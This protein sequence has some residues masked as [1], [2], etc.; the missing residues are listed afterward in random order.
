MRSKDRDS[1][2]ETAGTSQAAEAGTVYNKAAHSAQKRKKNSISE[3]TAE[4]AANATLSFSTAAQL[5]S[6]P[7]KHHNHLSV[8][9][10]PRFFNDKISAIRN[11]DPGTCTVSRPR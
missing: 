4:N 6:K 7:L 3:I 11:Q 8:N 1:V 5:F 2:S 9:S 10:V